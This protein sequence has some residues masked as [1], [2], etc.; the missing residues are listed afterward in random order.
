MKIVLGM[1]MNGVIVMIGECSISKKCFSSVYY[2]N[3]KNYL[4]TKIINQ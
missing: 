1:I 3:K 2:V 4:F